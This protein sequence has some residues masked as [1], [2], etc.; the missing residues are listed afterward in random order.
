MRKFVLTAIVILTTGLTA[1]AQDFK[2]HK[3][4]PGETIEEI[5]KLYLVTPYDIYALN[6]DAKNKLEINSVLIIPDSRVKNEP[7][8]SET[9][10]VIGYKTHKV[11]RKETLYSIS[12]LYHIE[13]DEIK[14]H[15]TNLYSETLQKGDKIKIPRYKTIV[16]QVTLNNTLKTY[17][18]LPKE[19]KWRVAYKFGITVPE[20][21]A[22]NPNMKEVL[23][24]GDKLNVPN[25]SNN[26]EKTI[27]ETYNYYTVQKSEGYMA[28]NRKLGVSK[29][30][31]EDLNP[32]LVDGGLKLGMVI[33]V[34]K[35]IITTGE[36]IDIENTDL[37]NTIKNKSTKRLALLMPYR[38]NKIDIDSVSDTK[39][40]IKTDSRLSLSLDFHTGVLMALDSAKHLGISTNLK[41]IDTRDQASEIT[42]ILNR[43]DFSNYDAVIGPLMPANFE[44]IASELKKDH[45]P[46]I[47]PFA[48]PQNLYDN[49]FQSVPS[50]ELLEKAIINFAKADPNQS[51]VV[52]I[53]DHKN[54]AI[55]NKL[56]A[57]FP[58]ARQFF[59]QK[60]K[61]GSDAYYLLATTLQD[62]FRE[63]TNIVFLQTS[64]EGFAS[65][66]TSMLNG[67]QTEE[68]K[69]VLM[70]TDKNKAFEGKEISNIHLSNLNFH[71]PSVNKTF[72]ATQ[73][74]NFIKNYKKEYGIEPNK[75]AIR[76]FDLTLDLFLRLAS[77]DTL[78]EASNSDLETEYVENKFRYSKQLFGGYT[79]ES[80][81][82]VMFKDL[83]I[84]EAQ[85]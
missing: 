44:R 3:V 43:N 83:T 68:I 51:H 9:K 23:Q 4:K 69:I 67:L 6:P 55:S 63:G 22:L 5:A 34:P 56:K 64:N 48:T 52:I 61:D 13:I 58:V 8:I 14:K 84:V 19:G 71:Y 79:N 2:T 10:E 28:L 26:E 81:Y 41:V 30:E 85:H 60:K 36:V 62:A 18:V 65:N 42:N 66:V 46:V 73:P 40:A 37:S 12:K 57:E 75:Y 39:K 74:N 49:V 27:E 72:N 21:E 31:L 17:T 54:K 80:V 11:K 7:L 16:S 47:S 29:E 20:L 70:T 35:D 38:L 59:S 33:K 77:E 50:N 45:V 32:E 24:P 78:Y 15:N 76:G 1:F 82:V 25:I 53:S